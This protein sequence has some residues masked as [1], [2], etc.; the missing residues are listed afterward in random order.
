MVM[1]MDDKRTDINI[2]F[3][4]C[5]APPPDPPISL[6]LVNNVPRISIRLGNALLGATAAKPTNTAC[7]N[8]RPCAAK[9]EVLWT[10]EGD[11]R[12]MRVV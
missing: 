6:A 3:I 8:D 10:M 2:S 1:S 7:I 9:S 11:D 4:H 12:L 5:V